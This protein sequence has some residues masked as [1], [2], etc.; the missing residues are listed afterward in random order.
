MISIKLDQKDFKRIQR[1]FKRVHRAIIREKTE[2]PKRCA[3]DYRDLLTR[4]IMTQ[5]FAGSYPPYNPRY[6]AWKEQYFATT[7]FLVMRGIMV[8]NLT[9]YPGRSKTYWYSG[10]PPGLKAPGSS[11][12]SAPGKGKPVNVNMYAIVNE[13]GGK[14]GKAYHPPRPVWVP[15]KNQY[16]QS[17]F[18]ERGK[19]SLEVVKRSWQ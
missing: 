18:Q 14:F 17:G 6:K 11:W 4:N 10:L 7:G 16:E 5:K 13:F 19:Q 3:F 8:G 9:V 15:T 12:F 1:G 2:L